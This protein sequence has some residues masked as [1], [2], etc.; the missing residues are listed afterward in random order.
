MS[1]AA[2][3]I[4]PFVLFEYDHKPGHHCLM[5]SDGNMGPA[6]EAFEAAGRDNGGYGWADLALHVMRTQAPE[7]EK[8]LDLDP[9]AGTFVAYGEDL[10]A[11]EELGKRLHAAFHDTETLP[12][13]I[14][15]A[16]YEY[17]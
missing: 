6:D 1:D 13:L 17:D 3:P 14:S 9:E 11:L 12:T 4:A 8:R 16:P 15:G 7:L 5:L 10:P 2:N